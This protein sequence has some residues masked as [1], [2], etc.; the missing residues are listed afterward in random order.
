MKLISLDSIYHLH[1]LTKLC[2]QSLFF[3]EFVPS[4]RRFLKS[5]H[6][7]R[8]IIP[9]IYNVLCHPNEKELKSVEISVTLLT[10]K[11]HHIV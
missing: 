5:K 10:T 7:A 3:T 6:M 11:C 8:K 1:N 4:V 2:F 9:V